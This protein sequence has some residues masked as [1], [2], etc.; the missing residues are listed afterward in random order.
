MS[1]GDGLADLLIG[2]DGDTP[3]KERSGASYVV[4][5]R[6]AAFPASLNLSDLDGTSGFRLNGVA[7]GDRSGSEGERCGG[8]QRRRA[9]GP[10]HRCLR[11]RPNRPRF[12]G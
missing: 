3:N 11:C 6:D 9:R 1:N 2:A 8:C 4:F 10:P 5:G 7:A 12:S